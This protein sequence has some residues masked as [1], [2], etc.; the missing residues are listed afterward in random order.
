M[1]LHELHAYVRGSDEGEALWVIGGLYT[2]KAIGAENA[3]AYSLIEVQAH[4]GLAT[5][6][7]LHQHEEEGFYVVEGEVTLILD[8][9]ETRATAGS[10]AFAPRGVSHAFRFEAP[11]AKL[12]LLVTPG[13]A[14]H[15]ALFRDIGETATVHVILPP[16]KTLPDFG[17][18]AELAARHG[19][20]IVAPPP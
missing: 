15:E 6:I 19:T 17:R 2:Y 3:N 11:G 4:G 7:H 13:G 20:I 1:T 9:K 8:D 10:F 5:P 18:L 14:G 16:S 12:L